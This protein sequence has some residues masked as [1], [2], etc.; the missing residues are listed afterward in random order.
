MTLSNAAYDLMQG[1]AEANDALAEQ[2]QY[3]VTVKLCYVDPTTNVFTDLLTV[4]SSRFFEY[5]NYRKNTLLEIAIEG[6]TF[7]D[8]FSTTTMSEYMALATHVKIDSDVYVIRQGDT[9]P[10][11]GTNPV[12]QIYLDLFESDRQYSRL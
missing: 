5:S 2:F 10:P 6:D 3:G 8:E 7:M 11:S 1:L 9:L 4:T 12:W